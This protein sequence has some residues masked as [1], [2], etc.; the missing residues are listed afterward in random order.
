MGPA[1][2]SS[3]QDT[4]ALKKHSFKAF[5][6]TRL[7]V[8]EE[9]ARLKLLATFNARPWTFSQEL[10]SWNIHGPLILACVFGSLGAF[11]TIVSGEKILTPILAKLIKP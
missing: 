7:A 4:S 6:I 1:N 3:A 10:D 9:R 11:R 5:V 2:S 8:E